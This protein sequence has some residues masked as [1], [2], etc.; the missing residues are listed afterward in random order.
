[1]NR[2][3]PPA[4]AGP[5]SNGSRR[6][7][8][9]R[10]KPAV[11]AVLLLIL[12][13]F[14]SSCGDQ[15]QKAK[16]PDKPEAASPHG[17]MPPGHP[18]LPSDH[19]T[20]GQGAGSRPAGDPHAGLGQRPANPHA[21]PFAE[22]DASGKPAM[23][24]APKGDAG[25][26]MV[27]GEIS[28]DPAVKVGESYVIYVTAVFSPQ[29]RAPVYIKKYDSPKFPFRF[30]LTGADQGVAGG[31]QS[32]RPLYVRAMISDT[33]EAMNN[34]NRTTSEKAYPAGTADVKLT[35]K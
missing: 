19:P 28:L 17:G 5:E 26:I 20:I 13:A 3:G 34:R 23:G 33:G 29:E 2:L 1:M 30:E 10:L 16:P 35:I 15:V 7:E 22:G 18:P 21:D 6:D 27:A 8:R 14:A 4:P 12:V 9:G 31:T 24:E 32:E 25:K 11:R